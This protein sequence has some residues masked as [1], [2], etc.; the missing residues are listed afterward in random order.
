[1]DKE[2]FFAA[3]KRHEGQKLKIYLDTEDK[4]TV[5]VGHNLSDNGISQAASD[6]I[7]AEDTQIAANDALKLV[8]NF[9]ELSDIRQEV[10]IN[11]S[12]NLGYPRLKGFR[13]F[14]SA[15]EEGSFDEAANEMKDSRWFKQIGGRA[16]ELVW[17]FRNDE[18]GTFED[19]KT[20]RE[21][22]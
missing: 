16:W 9:S 2:R 8:P 1:M 20:E 13:K 14:L 11:M 3:L 12:F 10:I 7:L 6:F 5:G 17:Q 22:F 15:I 4:W 21:H 18:V 19:W